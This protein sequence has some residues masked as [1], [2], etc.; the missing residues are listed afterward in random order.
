[1]KTIYSI[2]SDA[3]SL[4]KLRMLDEQFN[5]GEKLKFKT[6]FIGKAS[7]M[8]ELIS[9]LGYI[10]KPLCIDVEPTTHSQETARAF[11]ECETIFSIN[12]VDYVLVPD[13]SNAALA[14]AI[15]GIKKPIPI[16]NLEAGIR[17]HDRRQYSEINRKAIDS[18]SELYLTTDSEASNNLIEEGVEEKLIH[19]VGNLTKEFFSSGNR[20][21]QN[22]SMDEAHILCYFSHPSNGNDPILFKELLAILADLAYLKNIVLPLDPQSL[23]AVEEQR[24]LVNLSPN[25]KIIEIPSP[26]ELV[27][28]IMDSVLVLT[29]DA[30]VQLIASSLEIQCISFG[31]RS[32]H[33]TTVE[34]GTN[35]LVGTHL[36]EMR[37]LS[38]AILEGYKKKSK[39]HLNEP[40]R[41][42][43]KIISLLP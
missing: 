33:P 1:M 36:H 14:S 24:L 41:E 43:P 35:H 2:T 21:F 32:E 40:S 18:I 25:I 29:D 15:V 30:S 28:Y 12:A 6:V 3:L 22:R 37:N 4:L 11:L 39:V 16:L 27:D 31:R 8:E 9:D 5:K 17:S 42:I 23:K 38:V 7:E 26:K 19:Q 13:A 20:I 10:E 34:F